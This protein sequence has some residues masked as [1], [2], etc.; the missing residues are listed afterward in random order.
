MKV[1]ML[2]LDKILPYAVNPRSKFYPQV[3]AKVTPHADVLWCNCDR[4]NGSRM[5]HHPSLFYI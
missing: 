5:G 2:P 4:N 1:E 3:R